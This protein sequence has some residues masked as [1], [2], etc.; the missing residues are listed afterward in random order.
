MERTE[1]HILQGGEG[2]AATEHPYGSKGKLFSIETGR[3]CFLK[4]D[5]LPMEEERIW[6]RLT[7]AVDLEEDVTLDLRPAGTKGLV[8]E[9]EI[10]K[11]CFWQIFEMDITSLR[12]ALAVDPRLVLVLRKPLN[13]RLW[14]FAD[15]PEHMHRPHIMGSAPLEGSWEALNR[16]LCTEASLQ[17][18]G[19]LEGC[20]LD[21]IAALLPDPLA[22]RAIES[23]WRH[24]LCEG[25]ILSYLNPAGK[26]L[27]NEL[28]SI[29]STLPFANPPAGGLDW[30]VIT[31]FWRLN[32]LPSGLVADINVSPVGIPSQRTGISAEGCYTLAYPMA[33]LGARL[34]RPE[35]QEMAVTQLEERS[36]VLQTADAIFQK[37]Y[38]GQDPY[39]PNWARAVGWF[40]MGYGQTL[41]ELPPR[42]RSQAL[43]DNFLNQCRL[44]LKWQHPGGLWS[45]FIDRDLE[46]DTSGSAAILTGLML[47]RSLDILD[48][49]VDAH[50]S[51]GMEALEVYISADG[52][53]RGCAQLNRGGEALQVSPYRVIAP[54][55]MGLAALAHVEWQGLQLPLVQ[56]P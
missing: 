35:L 40:L 9:W 12:E 23:H 34:G 42:L 20:V 54:F 53:L 16:T 19:W 50:L 1:I 37:Q 28:Y 14:F 2:P 38:I 24:F 26:R 51:R 46:V 8:L 7:V 13:G 33:R 18:F 4:L 22:A 30:D 21:G 43:V 48:D 44:A 39:F 6:L 47:A 27:H 52:L 25:G 36:R 15:A 41:R 10:R 17:P 56:N 45:V 49:G 11:P 32:Q 3:Q 31:D 5:G 55:A 29:E